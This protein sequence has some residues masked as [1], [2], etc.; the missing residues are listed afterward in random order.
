MPN[1]DRPLAA[2]GL[3]SYRA[4]SRHGWIMI[5]AEDVHMARREAARSNPAFWDLQ[6]WNGAE[7]VPVEE[8][9]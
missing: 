5:G 3:I 7:Y 4:K 9:G 8:A 6:A 2:P 1:H